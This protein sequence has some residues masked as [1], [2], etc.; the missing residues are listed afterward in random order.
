MKHKATSQNILS[1][2]F[3]LDESRSTLKDVVKKNGKN[4]E[5]L[6]QFYSFFGGTLTC[7]YYKKYANL[8]KIVK[9]GGGSWVD[10][11]P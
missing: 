4:V 9:N 6:A 11:P 1:F 7:I 10:P 2:V 3:P 8:L 5:L